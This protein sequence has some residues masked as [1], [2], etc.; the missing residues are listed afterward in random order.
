MNKVSNYLGVVRGNSDY[1]FIVVADSLW[2]QSNAGRS[3][4]P[5]LENAFARGLG[6]K[7]TLVTSFTEDIDRNFAQVLSKDWPNDIDEVLRR[8][9]AQLLMVDTDFA[10]FDPQGDNFIL[11]D[12]RDCDTDNQTAI[13]L[14][15]RLQ[16]ALQR[17]D[18]LFEWWKREATSARS[19][20]RR[21]TGAMEAK[22]GIWGFSLDLK[23]FFRWD[24]IFQLR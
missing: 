5:V 21:L 17:G 11:V 6:D 3:L 23:E 14:L 22:P 2:S 9:P 10:A 8:N 15:R 18:E 20:A 19:I 16:T 7:G 12:F 13:F 4:L 1:L 24:S